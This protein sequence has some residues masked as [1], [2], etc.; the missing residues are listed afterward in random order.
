M[1]NLGEIDLAITLEPI[2]SSEIDFVPC[3]SDELRLVVHPDHQWAK[4]GKVDWSEALRKI[5]FYTIDPVTPFGSFMNI[6][7]IKASS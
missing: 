7:M 6:W 3:F 2:K 1:L 4:R 5:L